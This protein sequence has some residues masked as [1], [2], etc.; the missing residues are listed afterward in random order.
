MK[1]RAV[2]LGVVALGGAALA[3]FVVTSLKPS[4]TPGTA[5]K[6]P[7]A[8]PAQWVGVAS[9]STPLNFVDTG[10]VNYTYIP[11][12]WSYTGIRKDW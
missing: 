3:A 4:T 8:K 6:A 5:A 9:G 11:Q 10:P 1:R 12:N 2:L 7:Q